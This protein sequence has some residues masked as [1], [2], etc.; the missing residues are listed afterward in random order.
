VTASSSVAL[1]GRNLHLWRG[2]RHVLKG[3]HFTA[4]PGEALHVRGANGV[5]KTTLLRTLAGFLWPEEGELYWM[6]R[7]TSEDR[8]TYAAAIAYLGHENAMKADLTPRENLR[9]LSGIRH[10]TGAGEIDAALER[11]GVTGQRDLPFRSLSAGQRRR[12]SMARVLL[13]RARLW[14][15]DEPFTNL[16]VAGV[17]DLS[18][19]IAEHVRG[20]GMAILTAHSEL[21]LPATDLR[22]LEL[23]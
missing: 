12:V 23:A 21:A 18:G 3:L 1:E 22:R 17:R 8:D 5:G 13:S 2:E 16:D 15:L 19:L 11:L 14:L 20:G 7:R 6:G 10:T 4:G 9:Y